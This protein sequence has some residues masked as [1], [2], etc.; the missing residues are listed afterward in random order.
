MFEIRP[1]EN[2][3]TLILSVT[4]SLVFENSSDAEKLFIQHLERKPKII[5]IDC[6]NI[7][8][9]DSS[10]L[11]VFIK[12]TK[13]AG[14]IGAR[15]VFLDITDHMSTLLDV[16]KLNTMFEIMTGEEFRQLYMK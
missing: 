4:G 14:K 10:G 11:G 9:L 3:D 8:S 12:L 7:D 6:R 2:G 15:L 1:K 16:S 13:D 5:G